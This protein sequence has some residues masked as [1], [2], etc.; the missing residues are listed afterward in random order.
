MVKLRPSTV[1]VTPV[2]ARP[3]ASK[4]MAVVVVDKVTPDGAEAAK[5]PLAAG[6]KTSR[7]KAPAVQLPAR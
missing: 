5:E 7:E 6:L 1:T 2:L 4:M 3:W